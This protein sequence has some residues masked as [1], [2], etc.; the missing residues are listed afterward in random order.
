MLVQT[1]VPL[2]PLTTLQVGGPATTLL[3]CESRDDLLTAVRD[4]PEAL[5]LAGGSN[6]LLPDAGLDEVVLVRTRGVDGLTAQAGED[7]D[8]FVASTLAAGYAGLEALS[9]IPGTVGA[10]PIQNIGAYGGEAA[11]FIT[12]VEVCDRRTG[13][14]IAMPAADCGFAYRD[15]RFKQEPD[16]WLVLS[17][18][19]ELPQS[20][21]SAPVGYAELAAVLGVGV[22]DR[23]PTEQVREAVLGLR[24]NKGMVLDPS[25]PDS[26]SAGSFFTNPVV[27]RAPDG[28]PSWP[29]ADGRVKVSAAWLIQQA[30]LDKGW[31]IGPAGLSSKHALAVINR[32][33]ARADDLLA[34]ARAVRE[35]VR[36]RF[37]IALENEPVIV[38]GAL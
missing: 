29:A 6:V 17:V 38:G 16:R 11:T 31:G 25:D 21:A 37:G 13:G 5:V 18:R 24:R 20:G 10:S 4:H 14:V 27:E 22:G 15:S 30:G 3:V 33:G 26:V 2:A 32:G 35:R 12:E 36:E 28:A 8:A 7:W 34:V 1:D 19:F 9:G 23:A